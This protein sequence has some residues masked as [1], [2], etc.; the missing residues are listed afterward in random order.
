MEGSSRRSR[1][2]FVSEPV[3]RGWSGLGKSRSRPMDA[4]IRRSSGLAAILALGLTFPLGESSARAQTTLGTD[5][6]RPYNGQYTQFTYPFSVDN[7]AAARNTRAQSYATQANDFSRFLDEL[8]AVG[9]GAGAETGR[10]PG[11]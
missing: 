4:T 6:Y 8:S 7:F 1:G 3:R 2:D 10:A 9:T 11:R 5:P